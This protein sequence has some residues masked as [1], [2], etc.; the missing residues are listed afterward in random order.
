M[1]QLKKTIAK[2]GEPLHHTYFTL[3]GNWPYRVLY[4]PQ[5]NVLHKEN[6]VD[7]QDR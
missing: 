4:C 7:D 3:D 6:I 2:D 5:C 1:F